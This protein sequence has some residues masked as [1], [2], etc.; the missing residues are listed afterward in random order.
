MSVSLPR[1]DT[2][3][4]RTGVLTLIAGILAMLLLNALLGLSEKW[5]QLQTA[6][7]RL[8]AFEQRL[9]RPVPPN[10]FGAYSVFLSTAADETL[11]TS[12]QNELIALVSAHSGQ[13]VDIREMPATPTPEGL[14]ALRLHLVFEGDLQTMTEVLEGLAAMEQ[15]LLLDNTSIRAIG[16]STSPDRHLRASLDLSIWSE[17]AK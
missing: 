6:E 12:L 11:T 7:D 4:A 14:V 17:D 13:V 3:L 2:R 15:P 1:P 8:S 10:R 9:A 16:S 5:Q